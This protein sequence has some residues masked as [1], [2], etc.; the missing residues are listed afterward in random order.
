VI[1]ALAVYTLPQPRGLGVVAPLFCRDGEVTKREVA[2]GSLIDG[3]EL[4]GALDLENTAPA[5]LGPGRVAG[6][7]IEEGLEKPQLGIV[8]IEAPLAFRAA[9]IGVYPWRLQPLFLLA[10]LGRMS[11]IIQSHA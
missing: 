2:V 4:V 7:A 11:F 9:S 5:G 8:E 3:T 6:R 10:Q 1:G